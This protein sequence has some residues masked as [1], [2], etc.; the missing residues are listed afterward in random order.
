MFCTENKQ[1]RDGSWT[2]RSSMMELFVTIKCQEFIWYWQR[3]SNLDYGWIVELPLCAIIFSY[4]DKI[5]IMGEGQRSESPHIL[6][7]SFFSGC[8]ECKLLLPLLRNVCACSLIDPFVF[9]R[10]YKVLFQSIPLFWIRINYK[11]AQRLKICN[12][13]TWNLFISNFDSKKSVSN[14]Q[15]RG[16]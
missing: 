12:L 16:K 8:E 5:G 2:S 14:H 15:S 11:D 13:E 4:H 7:P 10:F 1:T 6:V 9:W 3:R